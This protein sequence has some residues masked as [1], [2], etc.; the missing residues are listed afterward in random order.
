MNNKIYYK[1]VSKDQKGRRHSVVVGSGIASLVMR[2]AYKLRCH[3]YRQKWTKIQYKG[4]E[5]NLLTVFDNVH[6]ARNFLYE[7]EASYFANV[8]VYC[9]EMWQVFIGGKIILEPP[10]NCCQAVKM[11]PSYFLQWPSGTVMA[12]EVKLHKLWEDVKS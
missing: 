3:Y 4:L 11:D 5:E 2:E 8:D 6:F 12:S 7:M 9:L 1:V 10:K